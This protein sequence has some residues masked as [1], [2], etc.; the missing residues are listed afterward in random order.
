MGSSGVS[1]SSSSITNTSGGP[2]GAAVPHSSKSQVKKI[3]L[4]APQLGVPAGD[5][6]G[7]QRGP[8]LGPLLHGKS[9]NTTCRATGC[10]ASFSQS[11]FHQEE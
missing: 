8:P 5:S 11:T 6:G 9:H 4:H 7:Q 2:A 10:A 1:T 3:L